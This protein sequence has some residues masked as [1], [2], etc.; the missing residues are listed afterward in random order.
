MVW[1]LGM[2]D[3]MNRCG[4]GKY[5]L[6]QV[7]TDVLKNEDNCNPAT[8]PEAPQTTAAPQP[9]TENPPP[10]PTTNPPQPTTNAPP[11]VTSAAPNPSTTEDDSGSD[12][13]RPTPAYDYPGYTEWCIANCAQGYCPESI[14]VGCEYLN[15]NLGSPGECRPTKAQQNVPGMKDWCIA[16]CA[17]GFCPATHCVDCT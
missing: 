11:P 10:Q 9:T 16:N 1:A 3:F 6:L 8:T 12:D 13:C 4:E 2:D 15:P 5:P 17:L 14:C 7:I